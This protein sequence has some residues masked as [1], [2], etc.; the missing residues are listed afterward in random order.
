MSEPKMPRP[1]FSR[2]SAL[3]DIKDRIQPSI[4][5]RLNMALTLEGHSI[6]EHPSGLPELSVEVPNHRSYS[7]ILSCVKRGV[8]GEWAWE[9]RLENHAV[10]VSLDRLE[11]PLRHANWIH[12]EALV[13]VYGGGMEDDVIVPED[14]EFLRF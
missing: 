10:R 3:Q 13:P 9:A 2:E 6:A 4:N 11:E 1:P 8:D 14:A 5:Y 7:F 12:L